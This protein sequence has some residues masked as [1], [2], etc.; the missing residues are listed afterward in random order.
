MSVF[1]SDNSEMS[2]GYANVA[3]SSLLHNS[4]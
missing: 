4:S 3:G 2:D 1:E